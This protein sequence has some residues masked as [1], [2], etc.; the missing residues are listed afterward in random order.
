AFTGRGLI[1]PDSI[2]KDW[3][4]GFSINLSY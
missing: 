3:V 1:S 2:K 4:T